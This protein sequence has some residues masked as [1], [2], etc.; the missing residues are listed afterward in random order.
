MWWND[1]KY[2]EM[3][4]NETS[5]HNKNKECQI[6]L[7]NYLY[8][9]HMHIAGMMDEQ[10]RVAVTTQA[11]VLMAAHTQCD[12]STNNELTSAWYSASQRTQSHNSNSSSTLFAIQKG[13]LWSMLLHG[14]GGCI[15]GTLSDSLVFWEFSKIFYMKDWTNYRN[16][17]YLFDNICQF[18]I[19]FNFFGLFFVTTGWLNMP[20]CNCIVLGTSIVVAVLKRVS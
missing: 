9:M 6:I 11:N 19:F 15:F 16:L 17:Y 8:A 20:M 18:W 13:L 1:I 14:R 12:Y 4:Q 5:V 2:D 7:F 3:T 10:K